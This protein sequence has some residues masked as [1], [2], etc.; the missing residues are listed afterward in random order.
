[1]RSYLAA[2]HPH[3]VLAGLGVLSLL[4]LYFL[5]GI[6]MDNSI[7]VF[8]VQ[9]DPNLQFY[10]EYRER[11][12]TEEFF[13]VCFAKDDAFSPETMELVKKVSEGLLELDELQQVESLA[14]VYD[15]WKDAREEGGI[16]FDLETFRT[17]TLNSPFY[18][19]LLVSETG[20]DSAIMAQ[21]SPKGMA[22]RP[23]VV[24]KVQEIVAR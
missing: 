7:D 20:E 21:L 13:L 2:K 9:E 22:D 5:V 6:R 19:G 8:F 11:F 10:N 4:L 16:E 24:E 15:I 23:S 14:K 1:M 18:V 12:G 3:L 17:D